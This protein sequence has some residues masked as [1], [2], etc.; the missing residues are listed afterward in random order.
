MNLTAL[1][2]VAL[3]SSSDTPCVPV[4]TPVADVA[5]SIL[6][7]RRETQMH[8]EK[9]AAWIELGDLLAVQRAGDTAASDL[10]LALLTNYYLGEANDVDVKEAVLSRGKVRMLAQLTPYATRAPCDFGFPEL[11]ANRVTRPEINRELREMLERG[12]TLG[13]D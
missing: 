2:M 10:V 8:P 1:A 4:S 3:M 5:R 13:V 11:L 7:A 6:E 9:D 12:E